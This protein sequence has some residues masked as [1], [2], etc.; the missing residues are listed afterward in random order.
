MVEIWVGF[1]VFVLFSGRVWAGLGSGLGQ[2]VQ[3]K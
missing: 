2:N 3:A 1:G